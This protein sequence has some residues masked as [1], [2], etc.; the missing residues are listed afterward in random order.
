MLGDGEAMS[1][2][3]E[4]IGIMGVNGVLVWTSASFSFTS[5]HWRTRGSGTGRLARCCASMRASSAKLTVAEP[6]TRTVLPVISTPD[7]ATVSGVAW[8]SRSR[9]RSASEL[10]SAAAA[11][12]T[13]R[14]AAARAK[15]IRF[16][17]MAASYRITESTR[18]V[19]TPA[20]S[21]RT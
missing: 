12:P 18:V 7:C 3:G 15:S 8:A 21:S 19:R 16:V 17:V 13:S 2:T 6:T 14:A 9:S 5:A 10:V 11:F 4:R 20:A 1:S